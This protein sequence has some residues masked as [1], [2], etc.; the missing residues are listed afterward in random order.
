MNIEINDTLW[1]DMVKRMSKASTCRVNLAC[2][3]IKKN[4]QVG[5]GYVGA[6]SGDDHCSHYGC[7]LVDNHNQY[8]SSDS[9]KSCIRTAHAEMNALLDCEKKDRGEKGNWITC[10]STYSPCINC[11]K[12]L[13]QIGVRTFIF[14]K[15]YKDER[16]EKYFSEINKTLVKE[17]IWKKI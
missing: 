9:G 11:L 8:G 10:Y 5:V 12:P 2:M 7:I 17:V 4:R 13:L 6:V 16:V 1:M 3:L 15:F 14:E